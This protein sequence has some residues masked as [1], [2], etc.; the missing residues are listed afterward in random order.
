MTRA[1]KNLQAV[2]EVQGDVDAANEKIRK[3]EADLKKAIELA[4]RQGNPLP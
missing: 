1:L 2:E 3:A 4:R